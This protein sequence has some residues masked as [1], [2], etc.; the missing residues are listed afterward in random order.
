VI[1]YCILSVARCFFS[2]CSFICIGF[3]SAPSLHFNYPP[4]IHNSYFTIHSGSV[5]LHLN[6]GTP[7]ERGCL[8][9][10]P[11]ISPSYLLILRLVSLQCRSKLAARLPPTRLC[12]PLKFQ[13]CGAWFRYY[14][15]PN[16]KK[17][18]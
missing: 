16:Q 3:A 4:I 17:F 9:F 11:S 7:P 12:T 8:I 1:S 2:I 15:Y 6:Q 10:S 5:A 13:D 14:L 18:V